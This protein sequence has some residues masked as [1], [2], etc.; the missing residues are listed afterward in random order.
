MMLSIPVNW[1]V[2]N[3][4]GLCK[5]DFGKEEIYQEVF[6]EDMSKVTSDLTVDP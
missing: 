2:T 1:G 3:D 4:K 6:Y 5:K